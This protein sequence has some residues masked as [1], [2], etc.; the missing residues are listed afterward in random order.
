[1]DED[2]LS[3]EIP[4]P[5][6]EPPLRVDRLEQVRVELETSQVKGR[7]VVAV[8][9]LIEPSFTV[10][11][12]GGLALGTFMAIY[13]VTREGVVAGVVTIATLGLGLVFVTKFRKGQP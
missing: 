10:A 9:H 4:S 11:V 6:Q 3:S 13:H 5:V 1:M 2:D 7:I 12:L 8:G